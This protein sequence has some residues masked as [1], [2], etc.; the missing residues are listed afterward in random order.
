MHMP[1]KIGMIQIIFSL[2]LFPAS[3]KEPVKQVRSHQNQTNAGT[4][5]GANAA[6]NDLNNIEEQLKAKPLSIHTSLDQEVPANR[7][8]A[9]KV[10]GELRAN[11]KDSHAWF[12]LGC[13]CSSARKSKEAVTA[14]KHA[15]AI[16]PKNAMALNNLGTELMSQKR[17]KEAE[18]AYMKALSIDPDGSWNNLAEVRHQLGDTKG[19][20]AALEHAR[21]SGEAATM[22]SY[23]RLNELLKKQSR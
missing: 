12:G 19:E 4:V 23:L 1:N 16:N 2:M 3:A 9:R 5:F 22:E 14:Y 21:A 10:I 6:I 18:A 17:L 13:F 7:P 11:I 20:Q 15:L 8:Y